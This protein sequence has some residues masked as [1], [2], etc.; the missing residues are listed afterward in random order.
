MSRSS[1]SS[2]NLCLYA[3]AA[4]SLCCDLFQARSHPV[5]TV[6]A[7]LVKDFHRDLRLGEWQVRGLGL[8]V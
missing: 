6:L 4:I 3:S 5:A 2:C 7:D 8:A 1:V